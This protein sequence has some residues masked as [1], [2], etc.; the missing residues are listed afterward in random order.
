MIT[1]NLRFLRRLFLHSILNIELIK[2]SALFAT[3]IISC[4]TKNL[5]KNFITFFSQIV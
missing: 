3:S 4:S 5:T 1:D 2:I